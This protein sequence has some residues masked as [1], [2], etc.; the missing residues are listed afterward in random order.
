M[1]SRSLQPLASLL[2]L[3]LG[4]VILPRQTEGTVFSLTWT[5]N[6]NILQT[7]FTINVGD[8]IIW[9]WNMPQGVYC[10]LLSGTMAQPN[11]LFGEPT[12]YNTNHMYQFQFIS[13][14]TFPYFCAEMGTSAEIIVTAS[15]TFAFHGCGPLGCGQ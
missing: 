11:N 8:T 5:T 3:V 7:P 10:N 14:G 9:N 1:A 6:Y 4:L 2:L 15:S 12:A 13:A